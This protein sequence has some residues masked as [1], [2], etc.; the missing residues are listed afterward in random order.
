MLATLMDY[1]IDMVSGGYAT[2]RSAAIDHSFNTGGTS[3]GSFSLSVK[4]YTFIYAT[5][6]STVSVYNNISV[7]VQIGSMGGASA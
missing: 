4:T 3:V 6:G 2:A 5:P 7:G 1:E